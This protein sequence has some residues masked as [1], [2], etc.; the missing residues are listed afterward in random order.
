MY[1]CLAPFP[2]RDCPAEPAVLLCKLLCGSGRSLPLLI[3]NFSEKRLRN[4]LENAL[5]MRQQSG[6]HS[7]LTLPDLSTSSV[8]LEIGPNVSQPP[9][10]KCSP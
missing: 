8:C 10:Q 4:N 2:N 9:P 5:E 1:C 7:P 3:Y 6:S